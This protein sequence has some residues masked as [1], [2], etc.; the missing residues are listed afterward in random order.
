MKKSR[1]VPATLVGSVAATILTGCGPSVTETR[2]CVDKYGR[3]LSDEACEAAEREREE[4]KTAVTAHSYPNWIYGGNYSGGYVWGGASVPTSG[5][6]VVTPSGR[7]IS[8]GGFG[9][10][11][12]GRFSSGG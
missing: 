7:V 2:H 3:V 4:R 10:I 12:G 6:R 1:V 9:T 11:G 5:A 8:R